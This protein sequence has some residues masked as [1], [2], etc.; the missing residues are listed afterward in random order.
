MSEKFVSPDLTIGELVAKYPEAVPKL[1]SYGI[2]CVG[3]GAANYE[4]ISQGLYGH[5]FSQE[6]V[7]KIIGELNSFIGE[8]RKDLVIKQKPKLP[9]EDKRITFTEAA[10]IK[11]KEMFSKPDNKAKGVR[12]AVLTGGCSGSTYTMEFEETPKPDDLV[13]DSYGVQIFISKESLDQLAGT[14]VD[15]V[16]TL[17]E[18]GFKFNNP[19]ASASC[20]CGKSFR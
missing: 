19:N 14:S 13:Y 10:S 7:T 1:Q 15:Y 12:I 18:S 16:D 5:G 2:H 4:S 20:G 8:K 17:N 11:L 6:D 9:P 3:C